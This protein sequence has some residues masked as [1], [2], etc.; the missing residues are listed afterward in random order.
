MNT[1]II[2]ISLLL[3]IFF[4]AN[5]DAQKYFNIHRPMV[6][7]DKSQESLIKQKIGYTDISIS[8]HSPGA[9][10]REIWGGLVR[11]GQ[12]WRAGANENTVFTITHDA[13]IEGQQLKAGTYGLHL[14]PQKDQWT[15]IFSQNHTSW[16][17][18]FYEDA[19][20]IIRVTVPV[21][22]AP[23]FREWM[24][25]EFHNRD[26]GEASVILTWA[27]KRAGF[28][29]KVDIDAIALEN[30]RLQLRSDAYWEWF[31]WCQ[32]AA[33]CAEYEI[34]TDE[35][36]EWID[37]SIAMRENFSNW[38]VKADLLNQKG[39][40]AGAKKAIERAIEVGTP[41]YV[42]RYARRFLGKKE[43]QQAVAIFDKAL[44]KDPTYWRALMNK[45]RALEALN[46]KADALKSY[47]KAMGTAPDGTKKTLKTRIEALK[48]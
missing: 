46:K 20:D 24:S 8:Y 36:L 7:P 35:A 38:D 29:I 34:N 22:E 33:Y 4:V 31:S 27:D 44:E 9:R 39:D 40:E 14:L 45:G 48:K 43:Y 16:G 28:N 3:G 26:R 47:E 12:V 11:Y 37:R 17:S 5:L 19:E 42:E 30:I 41:I 25:Y 2:Q 15:F 10:D 6:L 21:E 32:A 23:E 13:E 1:K 18:Y